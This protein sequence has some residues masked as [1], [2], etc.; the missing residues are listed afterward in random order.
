MTGWWNKKR[1]KTAI[2]ICAG[3]VVVAALGYV[4]WLL[5]PQSAQSA[6][7]SAAKALSTVVYNDAPQAI[8]LT[9]TLAPQKA[10]LFYP[11]AR[12]DPAAYAYKLSAVAE[13]GVAVVIAKPV[14]HFALLDSTSI[15]SYE[16]LLPDVQ[17]W[18]VG[19]HSLG[20]VK[21]CQVA[22]DAQNNFKGLVLLAA[23][24]SNDLSK[25][26]IKALSIGGGNDQLTTQQQITNNKSLMPAQ[27]TYQT[28]N[29]LNHAGFGDY[30]AQSGD[31]QMTINNDD[32]RYQIAQTI[33]KFMGVQ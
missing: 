2:T 17:Q 24:C 12:I 32:A 30:G 11:G 27:T 8:T 6:P 23:Y 13:Q 15:A 18:Y 20:G 31:G 3:L 22:G 14:A 21:A 28:V 9:P 5:T 10:L 25:T 29:G 26:S 16:A 7:L 19:G 1:K 33:A 4:V